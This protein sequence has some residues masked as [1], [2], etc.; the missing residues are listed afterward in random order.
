MTIENFFQNP[1]GEEFKDFM[2]RKQQLEA[3]KGRSVSLVA[4]LANEFI[5]EGKDGL[6]TFQRKSTEL[7]EESTK[8]GSVIPPDKFRQIFEEVNP[9]RN[10]AAI[11]LGYTILE[12]ERALI[13]KSFGF[14]NLLQRCREVVKDTSPTIFDLLPNTPVA[15]KPITTG[16]W[17]QMIEA[18]KKDPTFA[19][20]FENREVLPDIIKDVFEIPAISSS[21]SKILPR[22]KEY[23]ELLV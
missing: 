7:T 19:I 6:I 8:T 4:L 3:E 1:A 20:F 21:I 9:V 12:L 5:K 14:D 13:E 17:N 2:S 22:Y 15:T 16:E 10:T 11:F 18:S 23:A